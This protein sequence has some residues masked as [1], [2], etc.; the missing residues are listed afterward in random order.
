MVVILLNQCIFFDDLIILGYV[1]VVLIGVIF[2]IIL[3]LGCEV[4]V[5]VVLFKLYLYMQCWKKGQIFVCLYYGYNLC[6]LFLFCLVQVGWLIISNII[7]MFYYGKVIYGEYGFDNVDLVMCVLFLVY[8]LV[9]CQYLVVLEFLNVDVY[10]LM[11]YLLCIIVV[12]NDG[13]YEVVKGMLVL[14]VW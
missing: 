6:V 10:L 12:L 5:E 14:V 4:E 2:G 3:V 11:I 9:F 1:C 7:M 8:G 13:D